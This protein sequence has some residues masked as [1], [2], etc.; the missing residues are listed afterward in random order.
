MKFYFKCSAPLSL[1]I[2]SC[3]S[4]IS[5]WLME[6]RNENYFG[7]RLETMIYNFLRMLAELQTNHWSGE[8]ICNIP[9]RS[10]LHGPSEEEL[11]LRC[12]FWRWSLSDSNCSISNSTLTDPGGSQTKIAKEPVYNNI[13]QRRVDTWQV[14]SILVVVLWGGRQGKSLNKCE[15]C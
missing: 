7:W 15:F 8:L 6:G 13:R 5:P 12:Q 11:D 10:S 2:N 4:V 3:I 14:G 1:H 9:A